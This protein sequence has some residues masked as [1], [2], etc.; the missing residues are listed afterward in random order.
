MVNLLLTKLGY[1][2]SQRAKWTYT[3]HLDKHKKTLR[4]PARAIITIWRRIN[5]KHL[6]ALQRDGIPY[7]P[8]TVTLEVVK[9]FMSRILAYQLYRRNFFYDRK[10]SG[11]PFHRSTSEVEQMSAL[12]ELN[13]L[14]GKLHIKLPIIK[15][16]KKY[17]VWVDFNKPSHFRSGVPP[18]E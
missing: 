18:S 15:F 13:Y 14:T 16:F 6:T 3:T 4:A 11:L 9:T 5:Y 10:N 17:K 12:G 7:N 2:K 1:P 8:K